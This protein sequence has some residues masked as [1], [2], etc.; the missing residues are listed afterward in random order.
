MKIAITSFARS[1]AFAAALSATSLNAST[2]FQ[3]LQ[4]KID[5][6]A[7]GATIVLDRDYYLVEYEEGPLEITKSITLD[8]AGH[9][10]T[11]NGMCEAISIR[12]D[13]DLVLTNQV[14]GAGA[15]TGGGDHAVYVLG[16]FYLQAGAITGNSSGYAGGGVFVDHGGIFTMTGGAITNNYCYGYEKG[17]GG[18][19]VAQ[20]GKFYFS[21]GIIADNT[22]DIGGGV[23]VN[24]SE[25]GNFAGYFEMTGGSIVSNVACC[26]GGVYVRPGGEEAIDDGGEG[27]DDE[28]GDEGGDDEGGYEV[29]GDGD[30][31]DE[32]GEEFVTL[33]PGRFEMSGG[34]ISGNRA[35]GDGDYAGRGGGIYVGW[36]DSFFVCG[37]PVVSNNVN[38][39]GLADNVYLDSEY[40]NSDAII[41]ISGDLENGACI[42]VTACVGIIGFEDLVFACD[43]AAGDV[44]YFFSD[45]P[46]YCLSENAESNELLIGP[47]S[48]WGELQ[49]LLS[50]GG[51]V[52]LDRDYAATGEDDQ[53]LV[54]DN[55]V[56]LDLNGH[57]I[58]AKGRFAVIKVGYTRSFTLTNSVE[59]AGAIMGGGNAGSGGGVIV[60]GGCKFTMT[61]GVISNNSSEANGGGVYVKGDGTFTMT[62]G[63]ISNNSSDAY[64]GGV[65]VEEDGTFTMTGGMISGN[66]AHNGGGGVCVE[67]SG[68]FA[69]SGGRIYGNSVDAYGGGVFVGGEFAMSGGRI[70]GNSANA[71]DDEV[72]GGVYVYGKMSVSGSPVIIDNIN[73]YEAADNVYLP[74]VEDKD[75]LISVSNQLASAALIGVTLDSTPDDN[76]YI[77]FTANAANGDGR[78]FVSDDPDYSIRE[79]NGEVCLY[80]KEVKKPNYLAGA[81]DDIR[82]MWDAWARR[83]GAITNGEYETCFLLNISPV[84]EIPEGA[85]LLKVVDFQFTDT[86][87]RVE[88][89]SDIPGFKFTQ[90]GNFNT[91]CNGYAALEVAEDVS[92]FSGKSGPTV[93]PVEVDV[94]DD[95]GSAT[96][97][98]EFDTDALSE[99]LPSKLFV[100]PAITISNPDPDYL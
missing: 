21:G 2:D 71:K 25:D 15:V 17:G 19:F 66:S 39:S 76:K 58:D 9:T 59:G 6:A 37:S 89:G 26:G 74:T 3:C 94:D 43:A 22:S 48:A 93:L 18:V 40:D 24:N 41:G 38:S 60:T 95:T 62:G 46:E 27:G 45:N 30:G 73:W 36:E 29:F 32:G 31:D 56:E 35:E 87:I 84:T 82:D 98:Y 33:D 70:Y 69:M 100:R 23:F 97:D 68:E 90:P 7:D 91:L 16:E 99:K 63:A 78:Y 28:G 72:G 1:A 4:S 42:G 81:D 14:E 64:G 47:P 77:A 53:A 55:N 92:G 10:I 34:T 5:N 54:I 50:K 13:G 75:V 52:V 96:I 20:E 80:G 8:L 88:L 85:A 44:Q 79:K 57:T 65:F 12:E 86:G 83:Y 67:A 11:G 49:K 61:G 51:R